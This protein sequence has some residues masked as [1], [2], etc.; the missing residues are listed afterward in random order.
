MK[1][2]MERPCR[3]TDDFTLYC[4]PQRP[5]SGLVWSRLKNR[6]TRIYISSVFMFSH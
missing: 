1:T 6:I 4:T 3:G 5:W 2:A